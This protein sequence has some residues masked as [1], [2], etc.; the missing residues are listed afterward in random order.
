MLLL[1]G[2]DDDDD[3]EAVVVSVVVVGALLKGNESDERVEEDGTSSSEKWVR[4]QWERLKRIESD[5]KE[6]VL[7]VMHLVKWGAWYTI[8]YYAL[9]GQWPVIRGEYLLEPVNTCFNI[10]LGS[11]E[12]EKSDMNLV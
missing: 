12:V 7:A 9:N 6:W 10:F 11:G 8:Y 4:S 1:S 2:A 5:H 3:T